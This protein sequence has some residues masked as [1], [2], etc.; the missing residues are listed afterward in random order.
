MLKVSY[1]IENKKQVIKALSKRNFDATK[2][3]EKLEDYNSKRKKNQLK[4]EN[5][6]LARVLGGALN[7]PKWLKLVI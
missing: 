5:E 2:I 6:A 1:I 3:F 4:L 7:R